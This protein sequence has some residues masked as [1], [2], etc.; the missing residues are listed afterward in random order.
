MY[1]FRFSLGKCSMSGQWMISYIVLPVDT[2]L[3]SLKTLLCK[4]IRFQNKLIT[5]S[6][7]CSFQKTRDTPNSHRSSPFPSL[8]F[9][10]FS[11]PSG[12]LQKVTS[13]KLL[14]E[15]L[16]E[17]HRSH[18]KRLNALHVPRFASEQA[19]AG[20]FGR[21]NRPHGK[22]PAP[23]D[24]FGKF[25]EKKKRVTLFFFSSHSAPATIVILS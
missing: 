15:L 23:G 22:G 7:R 19:S 16:H 4:N 11:A 14:G 12:F 5:D 10:F 18:L 17:R 25:G 13:P 1:F 3:I 8:P 9:P 2:L 6:T 20:G 21:L 24:S